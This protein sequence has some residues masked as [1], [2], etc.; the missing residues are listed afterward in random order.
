MNLEKDEI[1]EIA[2][3]VVKMIDDKNMMDEHVLRGLYQK[4]I[5][6]VFAV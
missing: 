6:L 4:E 2:K 1:Y 5:T 3:A